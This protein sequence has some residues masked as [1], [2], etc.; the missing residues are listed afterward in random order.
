[1]DLSPLPATF[2]HM[3]ARV[4]GLSA[5]MGGA[6]LLGGQL[7]HAALRRFPQCNDLDPSGVF[8]DPRSPELHVAVLGD[9]TVTGQGL[10][11]VDDSWPRVLARRLSD[12]HRVILRSYAE[13]GSK[14]KDV[15]DR[16]IPVAILDHHDIAIISVGSNDILRMTPVWALERRLDS[17]V[18]Q[19][20][21]VATSVILFGIGDLGSIPRLPYPLDLLASGSGRVADWVHRRVAERNDIAKIDQWALTTEAFNSGLHMFASDLFHPSPAGHLAWAEAVFPAVEAELARSGRERVQGSGG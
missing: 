7:A 18:E 3:R 9:S 11:T 19:M 8:G 14:S 13:G 10:E 17:I 6:A 15:L 16:Q 1:M 2:S 4:M 5:F 21:Q 20:K 12:Q